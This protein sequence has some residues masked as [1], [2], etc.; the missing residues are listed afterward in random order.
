MSQTTPSSR[1]PSLLHLATYFGHK[2]CNS[3]WEMFIACD[4]TSMRRPHFEAF[5]MFYGLTVCLPSC[6]CLHLRKN[7]W[8]PYAR[9]VICLEN[10]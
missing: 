3:L 5:N 4:R 7:M 6:V 1:D 2:V 8:T 9:S 10:P